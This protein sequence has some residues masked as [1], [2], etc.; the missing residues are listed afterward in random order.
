MSDNNKSPTAAGHGVGEGREEL[1]LPAEDLPKA[2]DLLGKVSQVCGGLNTRNDLLELPPEVLN[3]V[4]VTTLTNPVQ[5]R[6]IYLILEP[7]GDGA[8][9]A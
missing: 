8:G 3:R 4:E 1:L 5:N 6:D 2:R 9:R 7:D